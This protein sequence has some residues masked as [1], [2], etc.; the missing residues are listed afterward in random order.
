M[1]P[2]LRQ[3]RTARLRPPASSVPVVSHC[4]LS[5]LAKEPQRRSWLGSALACFL[6]FH[7]LFDSRAAARFLVLWVGSAGRRWNY[8]FV[9]RVNIACCAL[10][11]P[12][13]TR[14]TA[15]ELFLGVQSVS[16]T[17]RCF[18]S[19][20]AAY[21]LVPKQLVKFGWCRDVYMSYASLQAFVR[22]NG[23]V[24]YMVFNCNLVPT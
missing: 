13:G 5:F 10:S 11:P 3:Q 22:S 20:S 16:G 17:R 1:L 18:P 15:V 19:N 24:W 21:L 9:S 6:A 7:G 2:R 14:S 8:G 4:S 23:V 12:S